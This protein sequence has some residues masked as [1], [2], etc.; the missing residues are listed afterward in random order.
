MYTFEILLGCQRC[1]HGLT[2]GWNLSWTSSQLFG[3]PFLQFLGVYHPQKLTTG[4]GKKKK[5][6]HPGVCT[7]FGV[8]SIRFLGCSCIRLYQD[9]SYQLTNLDIFCHGQSVTSPIK[10]FRSWSVFFLQAWCCRSQ[11]F[12]FEAKQYM[13][14][15]LNID[16]TWCTMMEVFYSYGS[17]RN[18]SLVIPTSEIDVSTNLPKE[19]NRRRSMANLGKLSY[20]TLLKGNL[21]WTRVFR[22]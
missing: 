14:K 21:W 1:K 6:K 12:L 19:R 5:I 7:R 17:P 16:C 18:I 20:V 10:K 13:R 3:Y 2:V 15:L 11:S 9:E 8:P 22:L 4:T